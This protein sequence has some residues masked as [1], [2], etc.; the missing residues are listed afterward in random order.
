MQEGARSEEVTK[1]RIRQEKKRKDKDI[2]RYK[3]GSEG[4]RGGEG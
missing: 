2:E 1:G 3:E 4:E